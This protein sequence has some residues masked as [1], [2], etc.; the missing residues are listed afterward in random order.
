MNDPAESIHV[1]MARV[2]ADVGAIGKGRVNKDQNFKFRGIEDVKNALHPVLVRHGVFYLPIVQEAAYEVR[3]TAK[4]SQLNATRLRVVFRFYGPAGD[5]VDAVLEGEAHDSADKST[6]KALSAAEKYALTMAFCIP[7]EEQADPDR[8]YEEGAR[9]TTTSIRA[10]N[11]EVRARIANLAKF[12][13]WD[14]AA[15]S[16]EFHNTY[17]MATADATPEDLLDFLAALEGRAQAT[18]GKP[19]GEAGDPAATGEEGTLPPSSPESRD[20]DQYR[21]LLLAATEKATVKQL[22]FALER[23]GL[24]DVEVGDE[25]GVMVTLRDLATRR[26]KEVR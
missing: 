11:K 22:L 23:D 3:T 7:T 19:E 26:L 8:T 10:R 13:G 17:G 12:Q 25:K 6:N 1:L 20:A 21:A 4:G 15:L 14:I 24:G 5:H 16:S 2:M 18:A 9:E